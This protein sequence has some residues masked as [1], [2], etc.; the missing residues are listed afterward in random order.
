M[1]IP[2]K[3]LQRADRA[4]GAVA[5]LLLQPVRWLRARREPR[6][7][8]RVLLVK[9]WGIGSLQLMTPAVRALRRRYPGARLEL[10]TL[11]TNEPFARQLG[12]FDE[13]LAL[14][15]GKAGWG[16]IGLR[17]LC[18][19]RSLRKRRYDT[20]FDFEFFTRFSAVTSLL[21]GAPT[22]HGFAGASTRRAWL[23]TST[24]PFNRYWH[25][26]RNFRC[27]AGG[28]N[29]RTVGIEEIHAFPI[30]EGDRLEVAAALFEHGLATAGPLVVLNPQAGSLS[31]ERRWPAD[32][33]ARLARMLVLEEGARV[34]V[35]GAPGEVERAHAVCVRAGNL[36]D[37]R[38]ASFAGK[39]SIGATAALLDQAA[40][41][42]T[43]DSGPMH[44]AAG[45]GVPTIGL[46]GPETP[47]M[48]R[49]LGAR[50]RWMYAPPVCS[51][52]I[53]VHDNKLA[54][55]TRG[56]AECM[57]NIHPP[58]V[59]DVVREELDRPRR[60]GEPLWISTT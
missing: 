10:L 8:E 60:R 24:V 22:S 3:R 42:V 58:R 31:L 45:M 49:P 20:V 32:H 54:S 36:H 53:N 38:L 28:E 9:F 35:I 19:L 39:L 34:V 1:T 41:F 4:L 47:V 16:R 56:H 18:L 2:M 7:V 40:V 17:I 43:N 52:C 37:G 25:V 13:T 15:V 26:A 57:T 6:D 44:L 48:Y 5:A 46:F 29:G 21:S 50:A 55:C 14:D 51:P 12:V 27:L 59:F 11:R 23:H 33:F 30:S